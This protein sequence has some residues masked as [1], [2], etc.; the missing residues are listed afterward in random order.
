MLGK[1][2]AHPHT[3]NEIGHPNQL[4][5][6]NHPGCDFDIDVAD[7]DD[8]NGGRG[9]VDGRIVFFFL[10]TNR[11]QIPLH[12]LQCGLLVNCIARIHVHFICI[13]SFSF[14]L[15]SIEKIVFLISLF[16][17]TGVKGN[18]FQFHTQRR[19]FKALIFWF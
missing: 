14:I 1:W 3:F 19:L 6:P 9:G 17:F 5:S 12:A 2:H 16:S 13:V 18:Y 8:D 7:D 10:K 11:L 4:F 15:Y